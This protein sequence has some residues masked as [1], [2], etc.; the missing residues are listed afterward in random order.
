VPG[1]CPSEYFGGEDPESIDTE[2]TKTCAEQGLGED[3]SGEGREPIGVKH[4]ETRARARANQN[5]LVV[6]RI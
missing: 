4:M 6:M 5:S 1:K 2:H 3:F